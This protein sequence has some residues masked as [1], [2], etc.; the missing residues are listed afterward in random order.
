[1]EWAETCLDR[2]GVSGSRFLRNSGTQGVGAYKK[3]SG[4]VK[5][6][7]FAKKVQINW[8][9]RVWTAQARADRRSCGVLRITAKQLRLT[10]SR[11]AKPM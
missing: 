2:T 7:I 11:M 10:S 8:R 1:M 4:A 3:G 6:Y 9:K 5:K